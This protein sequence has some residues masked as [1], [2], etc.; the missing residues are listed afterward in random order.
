MVVGEWREGLQ[1][2][3]EGERRGFGGAGPLV[4]GLHG[5]K[6]MVPVLGRQFFH[7]HGFPGGFVDPV[8]QWWEGDAV[9][10]DM[11]GT[12]CWNL[13]LKNS[14]FFLL[15]LLLGV[16]SEDKR[17]AGSYTHAHPQATPV[18]SITLYIGSYITLL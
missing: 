10:L 15:M 3:V 1:W 4:S 9:A 7:W 17:S 8:P 2:F 16:F 12:A 5:F 13:Q 11:A 6:G 18:A 14:L